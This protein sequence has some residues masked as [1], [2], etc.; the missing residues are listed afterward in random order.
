VKIRRKIEEQSKVFEALR[1]DMAENRT[2][3]DQIVASH[4]AMDAE[5]KATIAR[6]E[7]DNARLRLLL[8]GACTDE[9]MRLAAD[10]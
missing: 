8:R 10:A 7:V 5:R 9:V 1:R 2:R 6:L 3:L 4:E